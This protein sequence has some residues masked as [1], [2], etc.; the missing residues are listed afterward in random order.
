MTSPSSLESRALPRR[1]KAA[2]AAVTSRFVDAHPRWIVFGPLRR[3][4]CRPRGLQRAHR[5]GHHDVRVGELTLADPAPRLG[6]RALGTP[7][8]ARR[9]WGL[10]GGQERGA[11][12]DDE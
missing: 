10:V 4:R 12:L 5:S 9:D 2:A 8:G 11:L 3:E 7:V 6:G 1:R